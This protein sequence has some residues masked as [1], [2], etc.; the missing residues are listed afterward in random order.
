MSPPT[1]LTRWNTP[2]TKLILGCCLLLSYF[3]YFHK[4]SQNVRIVM[5][6]QANEKLKSSIKKMNLD[7]FH[8]P[9]LFKHSWIQLGLLMLKGMIQKPFEPTRR[10]VLYLKHSGG[11]QVLLDWF[12]P[13]SSQSTTAMKSDTPVI[14][15]IPGITGGLKESL[16]F[17]KFVNEKGWIAVAYHRRGHESLLRTPTFNIFGSAADLKVAVDSIKLTHPNSPIAL[18]GS[19]A[20]SALMV[21]FLG[22]YGGEANVVAAVGLS[23]GYDIGGMWKIVGGSFFD[24]YLVQRLKEFFVYRNVELLS[25]RDHSAVTLL[26]QAKSVEEFAR[27]AIVFTSEH[28]QSDGRGKIRTY[29]DWLETTCPLRVSHDIVVPTLCLNALDDPICHRDLVENIGFSMPEKN[30]NCALIVTEN[31]SHCAHQTFHSGL[32]KNWGHIIALE[33]IENVVSNDN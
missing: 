27:H 14:V 30:R 26:K 24:R 4:S 3:G 13:S 5:S 19:S 7:T 9:W 20:G 11:D 16:E 6:K 10:E 32:P 22:E 25:Q 2:T 31:G 12:L 17:A 23:P 8:V 33:F 28:H 21:R 18:V 15:Y 1:V 29:E